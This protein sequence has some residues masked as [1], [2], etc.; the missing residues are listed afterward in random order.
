VYA[1]QRQAAWQMVDDKE[2][3]NKKSQKMKNVGICHC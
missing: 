1:V 2:L 3:D